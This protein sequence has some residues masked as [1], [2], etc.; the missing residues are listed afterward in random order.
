MNI[1]NPDENTIL[2]YKKSK[3]YYTSLKIQKQ[4]QP[5]SFKFGAN[6]FE[7]FSFEKF[8]NNKIEPMH[9]ARLENIDSKLCITLVFVEKFFFDG[10]F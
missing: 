5:K 8:Y 3:Q 9:V 1:N 7:D 10:R 6:Q 4:L 2:V